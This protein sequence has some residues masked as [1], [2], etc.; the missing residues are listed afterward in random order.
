MVKAHR[1]KHPW[2][3]KALIGLHNII[4]HTLLSLYL[5]PIYKPLQVKEIGYN[6][7]VN[8]TYFF[9]IKYPFLQASHILFKVVYSMVILSNWADIKVE[10]ANFCAAMDTLIDQ[11][12][13]LCT[14]FN[15]TGIRTHDL[16]IMNC[17][18][19]D[20]HLNHWAIRDHFI[21]EMYCR[22]S[23]DVWGGHAWMLR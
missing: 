11:D 9:I 18:F 1:S 3:S 20:A 22:I 6:W 19:W 13:V 16:H 8:G 23:L 14:S 4:L 7:S 12:K 2:F 15:L 10:V 5:K 17:T 21:K